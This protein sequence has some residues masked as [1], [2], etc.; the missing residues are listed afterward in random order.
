MSIRASGVAESGKSRDGVPVL[1]KLTSA[2]SVDVVTRAGAGGMILTEGARPA[3]S[4]EVDMTKEEM[5]TLVESVTT[6]VLAKVGAPVKTVEQRL[7]KADAVVE[8][9]RVLSPIHMREGA[10]QMVVDNVL[11]FGDLPVKE[12]EL[13]T[14]KFGELVMVEARRVAEAFGEPGGVRGM[15]IGAPV[16]E[17]DEEKLRKE[18]KRNRKAREASEE[19]AVQTFRDLGMSESAAKKAAMGRA[20]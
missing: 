18:A 2:E 11:R 6:A 10:K 7:L 15:G 9:N 17:E 5:A 3:N 13:D 4:E 1:A 19:D 16:T 14:K 20:A 8:A 12:G